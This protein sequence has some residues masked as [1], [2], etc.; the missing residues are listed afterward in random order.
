MPKM[1]TLADKAALLAKM[2][3]DRQALSVP[4]ARS[5][6]RS[7]VGGA[8][9]RTAALAAGASLG[10]PKFIRQPLRAMA[11]VALR[12]RV[13]ELMGRM[14]VRRVSNPLPDPDMTR[15]EK[16]IE[17]VRAAAVRSADDAEIERLRAQLDDQVRLLRTARALQATQASRALRP[18]DPASVSRSGRPP[19]PSTRLSPAQLSRPAHS[20]GSL[21]APTG[22][23]VSAIP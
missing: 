17:E 16:M 11:A 5:A 21:E 13:N 18:S 3:R 15:L 23:D 14:Q 12:D 20:S 2:E 1:T 8:W 7:K 6:P 4:M 9:A 19:I 10:W 22:R